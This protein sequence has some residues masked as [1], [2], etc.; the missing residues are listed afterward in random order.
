[1]RISGL[2]A[3]ALA[4]AGLLAAEDSVANSLSGHD[5]RVV[6]ASA[7]QTTAVS[8]RAGSR[9]GRRVPASYGNGA[10]T[11]FRGMVKLAM[12]F[13]LGDGRM[14]T[15]HCGGTVIDSRWIVT[16]AHCVSTADGKSWD[17]IEI[18]AGDHD[19]DGTRTIRR[20]A[21]RAVIHAGFD[22]PTLSHDI[23]LLR[24][25]EP[26]PRRV[27]PASMDGAAAISARRGG[28]A[29]AAGWPVTGANAGRR[30]LQKTNVAV[31]DSAAKGFITVTSPT[32]RVEGVCQ[33]ESGGPLVTL[34]GNRPQLA[35]VLSGIQPG[36]NDASGEPCMIGGYEMYYTPIAR[37]RAW[38]DRIRSVCSHNPKACASNATMQ[39]ASTS[40]LHNRS[41]F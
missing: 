25:S 39:I 3:T 30:T 24:L 31:K 20:T 1:M 17:R 16:A 21:H 27:V 23:A 4:A 14:M 38:I 28:I 5:A 37:Y 19:L 6:T 7:P 8:S 34:S 35:G 33:G 41:V 12:R 2:L 10:Q 36:T 40:Q 22:Y 18:T 13:E 32:G 11:D 26:L 9:T 29:I 15:E